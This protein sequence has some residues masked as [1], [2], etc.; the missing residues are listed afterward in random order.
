MSVRSVDRL[1]SD[2]ETYRRHSTELMR[3]ATALVG[4]SDAADV[5]SD[6]VV[7]V[8]SS[9]SWPQVEDRR[10]YLYK[11]VLNAAR[12]NGRRRG[13]AAE[14]EDQAARLAPAHE[15]PASS[16]AEFLDALAR[17][18]E[19][20]R[21]VVFLAYWEELTPER[22]AAVLGIS[23]GAVRRHLARGR[24]KLGEA[25]DEGRD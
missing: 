3:F 1:D 21:A 17:L 22:T 16:V 24:M 14:R 7:A 6:A 19:R 25:L 13:R 18:S 23:E 10:A 4:P 8:L 2:E 11:A 20:Q 15:P 5:V 9:R 12:A